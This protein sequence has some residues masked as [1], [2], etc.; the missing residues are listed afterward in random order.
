MQQVQFVESILLFPFEMVVHRSAHFHMETGH[1][2]SCILCR[3]TKC[4]T[5]TLVLTTDL[6]ET[7][8]EFSTQGT[9]VPLNITSAS[10][11]H[12]CSAD[13]HARAFR[14]ST[15]WEME[16]KE[17]KVWISVSTFT[18][19]TDEWNRKYLKPQTLSISPSKTHSEPLWPAWRCRARVINHSL[20]GPGFI[21]RNCPTPALDGNARRPRGLCSVCWSPAHMCCGRWCSGQYRPD[22]DGHLS[23]IWK[24]HVAFKIWKVKSMNRLS[25]IMWLDRYLAVIFKVGVIDF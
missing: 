21:V 16:S 6:R 22:F 23:L 4:L 18:C 15:M 19:S 9:S 24:S 14:V 3:N 7:P 10:V 13:W 8:W 20:F 17:N 11:G 2:L 1:F 25:V 12:F 5:E